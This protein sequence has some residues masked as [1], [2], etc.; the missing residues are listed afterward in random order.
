MKIPWPA[1]RDSGPY[2]GEAFYDAMVPHE[3]Q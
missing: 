3:Q 1:P 2:V